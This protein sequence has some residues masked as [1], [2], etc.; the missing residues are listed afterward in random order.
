MSSLNNYD[1]VQYIVLCMLHGTSDSGDAE[2]ENE[3]IPLVVYATIEARDACAHASEPNHMAHAPSKRHVNTS[4]M[5]AKTALQEANADP[6]SLTCTARKWE[7]EQI[8]PFSSEASENVSQKSVTS[9]AGA[10]TLL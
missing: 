9:F 6:E 1:Q 10:G 7:A 4:N 3:H 5:S 8:A 2:Y